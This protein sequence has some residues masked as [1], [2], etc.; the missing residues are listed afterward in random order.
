MPEFCNV[1]L[2]VPLDMAFSYHVPND[3]APVIGGRVLVPF[4]QQRMMG[5]VVDLHDDKPKVATKNVLSIVDPAPVLDEKLLRLG[6]WIADYYLAPIGE[7]FRTMLPLTAEFKRIVG[8]RITEQGQ[9]ALHQAGMSGSSARSQRTPEEQATEFRVLDYLAA[10]A[11]LN[12]NDTTNGKGTAL[13]VPP[14]PAKE[15]VLAAEGPQFAR[16]Q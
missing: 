5:I 16:E 7:V 4:R 11:V 15:V 8:Y 1:A 14:N 12:I 2:P 10:A 6:R 13:A 9:N 3:M